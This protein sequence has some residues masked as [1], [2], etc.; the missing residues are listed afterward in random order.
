MAQPSFF[1]R[2]GVVRACVLLL[3]GLVLAGVGLRLYHWMADRSLWLDEAYLV[4][5]VMK[6]GVRAL[7]E[8]LEFNQ[9]APVLFLLATEALTMIAGFGEQ[10]LRFIPLLGSAGTLLIFARLAQG[11]FAPPISLVAVGLLAF[12]YP[13][14]Y[15]AQEFKQYSLEALVTTLLLWRFARSVETGRDWIWL[16]IPGA[17][18]IFASFTAPFVLAGVG[19]ALAVRRL[20]GQSGLQWPGLFAVAALWIGLFAV[21]YLWFLRTNYDSEFMS[22]YWQFARPG[23][24]F[25]A[26]GGAEWATLVNVLFRYFGIPVWGRV[27]LVLLIV[28]GAVHALIRREPVMIAALGAFVAYLIAVQAGKAPL[29]GRLILFL[30]P[31]LILLVAW[32]CSMLTA[33]M[34]RW[35]THLRFGLALLL[36]LMLAQPVRVCLRPIVMQ[37]YREGIGFL[38]AR[39][40]GEPVYVT[41]HAQSPFRYYTRDNPDLLAAAVMGR[42]ARVWVPAPKPKEGPPR[43]RTDFEAAIGEMGSR[44]EANPYWLVVAHMDPHRREFLAMIE[45]RLGHAPDPD[46][47]FEQNGIGVYRLRRVR[48]IDAFPV[49]SPTPDETES[50]NR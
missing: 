47:V 41:G 49:S 34:T 33:S 48:E 14:V 24:P 38:S 39:H 28:L 1:D 42:D 26:E 44:I 31:V 5:S 6:P 19:V 15:Y 20:R 18:S 22:V 45:A 30:H 40:H 17:V 21:N 32:G 9:S 46:A 7:F 25:T 12:S 2:P 29:Y 10:V 37:H 4:V 16:W 27:V 35:Q 3:Y 43:T 11:L 13:Q 50:P 36:M 23:L 8:P